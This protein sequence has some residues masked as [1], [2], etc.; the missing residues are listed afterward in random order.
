MIRNLVKAH[1]VNHGA[2]LVVGI[3]LYKPFSSSP[4]GDII[5]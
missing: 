5:E 3:A 1:E 2:I 4:N